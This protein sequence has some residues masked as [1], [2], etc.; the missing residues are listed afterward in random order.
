MVLSHS[1]DAPSL[2]AAELAAMNAKLLARSPSFLRL[3]IPPVSLAKLAGHPG[4]AFVRRPIKP[5]ALSEKSEGVELLKAERFHKL[6]HLGEGIKVAIIDTKFGRMEEALFEG[7]IPLN[8][9]HKDFTGTGFGISGP[10]GT[11]CAEIVHDVAPA[12]ELHLLKIDDFVG[13]ENAAQYVLWNKIQIVSM[14]LGMF[15]T[16]GDG[17]GDACRIAN[18]AAANGVL[19]INSAGNHADKVLADDFSDPDQNNFHNFEDGT[20]FLWL[21]GVEVGST[22]DVSLAWEGWP[23]TY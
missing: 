8:T 21:K 11:A 5:Q 22:I 2:S 1:E 14:S 20:Q 16:L 15:N 4:V 19:W 10:H 17:S 18:N 9:I 6:G 23:L 3:E 7:E 12:A 13:L